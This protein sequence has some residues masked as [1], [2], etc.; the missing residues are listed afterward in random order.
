MPLWYGMVWWGGAEQ[1][2]AFA[3]FYICV[4]KIDLLQ[5]IGKNKKKVGKIMTMISK[6]TTAAGTTITKSLLK[7]GRVQKVIHFSPASK[8]AKMQMNEM[9]ILKGK[10]GRIDVV[11]IRNSDTGRR[12][13]LGT[14]F[15]KESLTKALKQFIAN[16]KQT[17]GL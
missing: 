7:D 13:F 16:Q 12:W 4:G 1:I 14:N 9:S 5:K 17:F 8:M 11:D 15:T 2:L 6:L 3:C 10:N